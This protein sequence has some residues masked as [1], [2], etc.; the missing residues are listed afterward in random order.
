[1]AGGRENLRKVYSKHHKSNRLIFHWNRNLKSQTFWNLYIL[2]CFSCGI[3][4]CRTLKFKRMRKNV[5]FSGL[6]C[7]VDI[8]KSH[9]VLEFK[10]FSLL[11]DV[12]LQLLHCS[13][14]QTPGSLTGCSFFQPN[15]CGLKITL[16]PDH[17]PWVKKQNNFLQ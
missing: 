11:L 13:S 14:D 8:I 1:M 9:L 10:T 16:R 5:R 15:A 17:Y 4:S 7:G 12:L 2:L 6:K 3:T